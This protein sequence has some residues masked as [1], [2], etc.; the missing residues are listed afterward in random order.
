M[1]VSTQKS[2]N[3]SLWCPQKEHETKRLLLSFSSGAFTPTLRMFSCFFFMAWC[4]SI[5]QKAGIPARPAIPT[6]AHCN[7]LS[8]TWCDLCHHQAVGF[9]G[10]FPT[11][12]KT[13]GKL[14]PE[15]GW[16]EDATVS[17]WGSGTWQVLCL[18]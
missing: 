13:N 16:L 10:W 4:P 3:F 15:N 1:V 18:R 14:A 2:Q 17:F 6:E 11:T 8:V 9:V 12:P 7:L 5:R